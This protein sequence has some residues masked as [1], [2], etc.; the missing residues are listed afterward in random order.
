LEA[1]PGQGRGGTA[2][3]VLEHQPHLTGFGRAEIFVFDFGQSFLLQGSQVFRVLAPEPLAFVEGF[4]DAFATQPHF[5]PPHLIHRLVGV[6]DHLKL[7]KHHLRVAAVVRHAT[8]IGETHEG[9]P[10]N[11]ISHS[12]A[13]GHFVITEICDGPVNVRAMLSASATNPSYLVGTV[14]AHGGDT[15][16]VVRLGH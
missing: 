4:P 12:D 8:L 3:D 5:G 7:V 13:S 2:V 14:Q 15:N 9:Q 16:V 6:F 11:R 1:P 10:A